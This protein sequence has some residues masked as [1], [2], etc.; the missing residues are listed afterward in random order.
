MKTTLDLC[1]HCNVCLLNDL[2]FLKGIQFYHK[3]SVNIIFAID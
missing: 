3:T 1:H 2:Y